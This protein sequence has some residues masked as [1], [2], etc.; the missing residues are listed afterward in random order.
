MKITLATSCKLKSDLLKKSGLKHTCIN[1]NAEEISDKKNI[2]EYTMEISSIKAR[3]G[4]NMVSDGIIIGLDTVVD[5]NGKIVEKPKTIEEGKN[6]LRLASNNHTKVITGI[7]V[8]NLDTEEVVTTFQETKVYIK[9]LNEE[10]IDFYVKNEPNILNVSGF[11][12]EKIV[13][14][15]IDRIEGSYYNILGA[16]VEKIYEIIKKQ[17]I[18]LTD[19]D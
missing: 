12:V 6:N 16:P 9:E 5:I 7:T 19:I 4:A 13:S 14:C 8:I 10:E 18:K 11:V 1:T 17:G 2:Y 3:A 15:Y